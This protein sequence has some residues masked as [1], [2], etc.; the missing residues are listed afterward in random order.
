MTDLPAK[1]CVASVGLG[2]MGLPIARHLAAAGFELLTYDRDPQ[3]SVPGARAVGSVAE[4]APAEVVIVIVPADADVIEV[5]AGSGGLLA[6]CAPGTVVVIS[7]SV[8][9][10][11]CVELAR[12]AAEVGIDVV[13]AALT[14]GVRGAESGRLNLLVGADPAVLDRMGDVLDA[15]ASSRHLLGEVGAGQVGK[16][17][18]NLIHWGQIVSI[19]EALRLAERLGVPAPR[20]RAALQ[21][22]PTGSR[23]LSELELMRFTWFAKDIEIAQAL[24]ASAGMQLPQAATSRRL[25]DGITVESVRALLG[26]PEPD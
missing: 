18:N 11:T 23:T 12:S 7:A 13:D 24:A 22:G 16:A 25:M 19:V 3:A 20:L 21:D 6:H 10:A 26:G 9:P 5:V 15:F 4:L 17:A 2:A 14:G 1:R 8:R